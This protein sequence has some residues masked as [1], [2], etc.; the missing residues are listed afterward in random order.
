MSKHQLWYSA[1]CRF[2]QAFLEEL[3]K[4]P[5]VSQF[6][7]ICIDPSPN[8]PPLP[9]WLKV[10]PSMM[11]R[12]E[13]EPRTGPGPVNNWLFEAK[14]GGGNGQAAKKSQNELVAPVY[15]SDLNV[16]AEVSRPSPAGAGNTTGG[17]T[18]GMSGGPASGEPLAYYGSEMAAGKWSDSFSF[19]TEHSVTA[20][21]GLNPI[22]RN[23]QS[24]LPPGA[25]SAIGGP[26]MTGGGGGGAANRGEKRSAKEDALLRDFEAYSASRDR[27]VA[28]PIARR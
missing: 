13:F 22:E 2:C 6:Q 7:L 21:K 28:G 23:F 26:S 27:D 18:T 3:T 17:S 25:G 16:R 15:N 19:I 11:V 9:S 8:R 1:K 4:T 14:L 12:G 20:E 5:L 10:V 24:V